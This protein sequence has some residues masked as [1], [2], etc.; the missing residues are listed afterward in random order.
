LARMEH[1][2]NRVAMLHLNGVSG[3]E[4]ERFYATQYYVA[5]AKLLHK[6]LGDK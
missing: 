5:E 3:G 1:L 6:V 4:T 2:H